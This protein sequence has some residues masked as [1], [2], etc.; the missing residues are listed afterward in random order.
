MIAS[1]NAGVK[2]N[3][4]RLGTGAKGIQELAFTEA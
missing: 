4:S 2:R 3:K 1:N